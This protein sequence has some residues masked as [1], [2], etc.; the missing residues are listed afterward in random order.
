MLSL[1]LETLTQKNLGFL[2]DVKRSENI[3]INTTKVLKSSL[4]CQATLLN[5]IGSAS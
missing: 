2:C 3:P 5:I 4:F 1:L